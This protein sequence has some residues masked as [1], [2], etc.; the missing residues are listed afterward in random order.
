MFVTVSACLSGVAGPARVEACA[1]RLTG[2]PPPAIVYSVAKS[3]QG[4]AS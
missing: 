3:N 4:V 2:M 1:G